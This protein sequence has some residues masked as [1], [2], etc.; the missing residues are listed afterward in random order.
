MYFL[1]VFSLLFQGS[2]YFFVF[3]VWFKILCKNKVVIELFCYFHMVSKNMQ[4]ILFHW[5][6]FS[7][8]HSH[9]CPY[10]LF[11]ISSRSWVAHLSQYF[12]SFKFHV[13]VFN[14][15]V[16]V[17]CIHFYYHPWHVLLVISQSAFYMFLCLKFGYILF[18]YNHKSD[19]AISHVFSTLQ[20]EMIS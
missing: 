8:F 1:L 6:G 12:I 20:A 2:F 15:I 4:V 17:L 7:T 14:C 13:K 9:Y 16:L 5:C 18:V 10:Y 3:W 11:E 19:Q